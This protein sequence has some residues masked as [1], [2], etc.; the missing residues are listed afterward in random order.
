VKKVDIRQSYRGGE[1]KRY[2]YQ[3]LLSFMSQ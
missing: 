2:G 1:R 3:T